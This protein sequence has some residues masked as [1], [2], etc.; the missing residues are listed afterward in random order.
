MKTELTALLMAALAED[1][2]DGDITSGLCV[3]E[4]VLAVAEI[5]AKESGTFF[6]APIVHHLFPLFPDPTK[7]IHLHED[8]AAFQKGDI[9]CSLQGNAVTLLKAERVLLN[10]LQRLSGITTTTKAFVQALDAAHIKVLDTRKTTPTFRHLERLAVTA[11]GGVNHRLNLSDMILIKDNHLQFMRN[12][13]TLQDL[14]S[15]IIRFKS[16]Y[17]QIKVEIEVNHIDDLERLPLAEVDYILLDNMSR[18]DIETSITYFKTHH[19]EAEIEISGNM[20]LDTIGQY[21]DLPIHRISVGSLTHS[22]KAIDL[23]MEFK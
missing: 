12:T 6:G 15:R 20:T 3:S 18:S 1:L 19:I 2:P 10:F 13:D 16:Q 23:S 5:R 14:G 4:N 11:G 9:L 7:V 22:V 17:P 21:R 8:G